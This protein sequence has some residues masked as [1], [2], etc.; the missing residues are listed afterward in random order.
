VC[1]SRSWS[2]VLSRFLF[3]FVKHAYAHAFITFKKREKLSRMRY[4]TLL[5]IF[6]DRTHRIHRR[7]CE[8]TGV[9]SVVSHE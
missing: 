3:L 2:I 8:Y 7:L 4:A 5:T 9:D 6:V 1:L